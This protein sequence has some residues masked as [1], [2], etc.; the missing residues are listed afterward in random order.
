[1]IDPFLLHHKVH[2][3]M[4]KIFLNLQSKYGRQIHTAPSSPLRFW[5]NPL[6]TLRQAFQIAV[7]AYLCFHV[8]TSPFHFLSKRGYNTIKPTFRTYYVIVQSLLIIFHCT[9]DN[10]LTC[11]CLIDINLGPSFLQ[12]S[13]WV[14]PC[15]TLGNPSAFPLD[16]VCLPFPLLSELQTHSFFSA[17][18]SSQNPH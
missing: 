14:Q 4:S 6:I 7:L 11:E 13:T 10:N 15:L 12:A 18:N 1:M 8:H 5:C 17:L 2:K 3:S 16:S 9:Q